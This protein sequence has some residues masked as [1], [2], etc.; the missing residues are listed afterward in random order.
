MNN[1]DIFDSDSNPRPAP[2]A[3]SGG[4]GSLP[5]ALETRV[6]AW[7]LGEAS[8]VEAAEL[9]RLCTERPE[10][11]V[12]KRRIE[13]IHGLVGAVVRPSKQEPL[14]L[15]AGRRA[16]L[17][18]VIGGE[19]ESPD[20]SGTTG[21]KYPATHT[22]FVWT[23]WAM[24]MAACLALVLGVAALLTSQ[25]DYAP[26]FSKKPKRPDPSSVV[27]GMNQE[28]STHEVSIGSFATTAP[29]L[30]SAEPLPSFPKPVVPASGGAMAAR[31]GEI[32]DESFLLAPR[33][34][35]SFS[36]AM[37]EPVAVVDASTTV[38]YADSVVAPQSSSLS[39][40]LDNAIPSAYVFRGKGLSGADAGV[41]Y[42]A[43]PPAPVAAPSV[44]GGAGAPAGT[45][46][47]SYKVLSDDL[48]VGPPVAA[49]N[50]D[51]L[52]ADAGLSQ[53][54][55]S[56]TS[57]SRTGGVSIT[58]GV[59]QDFSTMGLPGGSM[60]VAETDK[61]GIRE[62]LISPDWSAPAADGFAPA[63][64]EPRPTLDLGR[65][66]ADVGDV[67]RKFQPAAR[68]QS[69]YFGG[70]ARS[71]LIAEVSRSW[72]RPEVYPSEEKKTAQAA[73]QAL[74]ESTVI[75][76]INFNSVPLS[77]ALNSVVSLT[78]E[79]DGRDGEPLH[80]VFDEKVA[81]DPSVSITLRKLS[82]KR[83]L[84]FITT[85]AGYDYEVRGDAIYIKPP[86]PV[87]ALPTEFIP[88]SRE[89][90]AKM[91]EIGG[92]S[93]REEGV[94]SPAD[95]S[96]LH[97]FLQ[98]AG[99]DFDSLPGA[100]LAYD[101]ANIVVTQTP[102]NIERLR[103]VVRRYE[104]EA[105]S[106][107]FDE[108]LRAETATAAQS[109]STFSL[110]VSDAS[111]RLACAAIERG[112]LPDPSTIRPE[113][114]YNVFDYGDPAPAA[115]EPVACRVEQSAHPFLQQRN[116]VRIAAKVPAAG[117]SAAQ[118]LRLTVL[119]DTSGSMEREDRAATVRAAL[120]SLASLL[121]PDDRVTLIGFARTPRLLAF[122]LPGKASGHLVEI[123]TQTP[124]EGGT[125]LEEALRLA[126]EQARL[127]RQ[128]GAQNRIVLLTDGAANLGNADPARL[129]ESVEALRHA[130]IAFDACGVVADGLD[131]G[132]LEALT[133]KGDGR[134]VVLGSPEEADANF[135]RQL[136]GAFR[137]AAKDV[138]V[139]VRFNPARVSTW[140]LIGFE[141]H[142]LRTED[143]RDNTVDAAEL[144][145]EEAAN[146]L[147]QVQLLPEGEGELG[148]V[149]VRFLDPSSGQYVERSWVIGY[150]AQAPAFARAGPA[151][152]L[153]GSAAFLAEKLRG[154]ELAG[155]VRLDEFTPVVNGLGAAYPE[156]NRVLGFI[157]L[158]RLTRRVL[159]E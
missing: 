65:T 15:S 23:A 46:D 18:A 48:Y 133:R 149:F 29:S 137:P 106:R 28:L 40:T 126:G 93:G 24:P 83:V 13:A 58:A 72:Q 39:V 35:G 21:N 128:D 140:R 41:D 22:R 86:A 49:D 131:D 135:A 31:E 43:P 100:A 112:E 97:T 116:L 102:R 38:A 68:G 82:T 101:G 7:V 92:H 114:F 118:P 85:S 91:M 117:R 42:F 2:H 113:E 64:P 76:A 75:P 19:S 143:F 4:D 6:V 105:A 27:L 66:S 87:A 84:D 132:V 36:S 32:Q 98:Q 81:D 110:H 138:K 108:D 146:A 121:G 159:G 152:R 109:V 17:L 123:A 136:A 57:G 156:S 90:V 139:Q 26:D 59:P 25:G 55:H 34:P 104:A 10:L 130:G 122:A 1:D 99:V 157:E 3:D 148:E 103:A 151:M 127:L 53:W 16:K 111:Y 141:Q 14:R 8:A 147:Y 96:I 153:A 12:F 150:D 134:Y 44:V 61:A 120:G 52:Y 70:D 69:Q 9:E 11:A 158:F 125:N 67:Q 62:R 129:A 74:L 145:A 142:R 79:L 144:A 77:K 60:P 73:S 56:V 155:Q 95:A 47:M 88:V 50:L 124:A 20:E 94:V 37:E 119:L 5:P 45:V 78:D 54:K 30:A 71:S 51:A 107:A 80:I 89:A 33:S 63:A 115:G 154:G